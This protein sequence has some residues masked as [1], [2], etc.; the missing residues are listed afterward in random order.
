MLQINPSII[1]FFF[2]TE[3]RSVAQAR[4]QWCD[5]SSLQPPPPQFKRFSCLSL[6]GAGI[7]GVHHH[8]RLIFVFL[9]ERKF[10]H[11]GQAGLELLISSDLPLVGLPKFWDYRREPLY[12]AQV[13]FS[14]T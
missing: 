9:V 12:P 4:G 7:T 14:I 10:C 6:Q 3:S 2:E 11:V 5:L 1:F 13:A 8:T